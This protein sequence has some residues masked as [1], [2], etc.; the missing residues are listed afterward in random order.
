VPAA[1]LLG[2]DG[3]GFTQI[4]EQLPYER[5]MIAVSAVSTAERALAITTRHARS[6][7]AFG[8][9]LM[10][11]QHT[12]FTLADCATLVRVGRVFLDDCVQRFLAGRLD[13]ATAAMAK[14]WL[15]DCEWRVVDACLQIHGGSGYVLDSPIARMWA[16]ARAPRIYGG[17]NEVLKE[18]IASSL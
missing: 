3:Q 5:L 2:A 13:G 9:P 14:S 8:G 11:L 4:V 17:A 16:N 18:L 1:N 7:M 15:T 12:R 6:R 10:D